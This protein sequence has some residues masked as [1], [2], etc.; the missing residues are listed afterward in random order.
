MALRP[1]N[2]GD[3]PLATAS[4]RRA[5]LDMQAAFLGSL[6][7]LDAGISKALADSVA[8][9]AQ[10]VVDNLDA[11]DERGT[12]LYTSGRNL[13]AL[14]E[15][16]EVVSDLDE[17]T[18]QEAAGVW[19]QSALYLQRAILDAA[20]KMGLSAARDE[21][22]AISTDLVA[23][24]QKNSFSRLSDFGDLQTRTVVDL[25]RGLTDSMARGLARRQVAAQVKESGITALEAIPGKRRAFSLEER[26]SM[27]AR[28]ES[29]RVQTQMTDAFAEAAELEWGRSFLNWNLTSHHDLCLWAESMAWAPVQAF[30][31]GPGLPPRHP[32]CGCMWMRGMKDWID[33]DEGAAAM[34]KD[35]VENL[36]RDGIAL[37][38]QVFAKLPAAVQARLKREAPELAGTRKGKAAIPA[39]PTPVLEAI[40]VAGQGLYGQPDRI[41]ASYEGTDKGYVVWPYGKKPDAQRLSRVLP[42]GSVLRAAEAE[43][44]EPSGELRYDGKMIPE[45]WVGGKREFR[46]T[47][48]HAIENLLTGRE[49]GQLLLVPPMT[50]GS[51]LDL[52]PKEPRPFSVVDKKPPIPESPKAPMTK[53]DRIAYYLLLRQKGMSEPDAARALMR[54]GVSFD[55]AVNTTWDAVG[56]RAP[57][58]DDWRATSEWYRQ[59]EKRDLGWYDDDY[60]RKY[61]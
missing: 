37:K 3:L 48:S 11:F 20:P 39:E 50:R 38:P 53:K 42:H 61:R 9:Q 23:A 25:K 52:K 2:F 34:A 29:V 43:K 18:R 10:V 45:L 27:I 47:S 31:D 60:E 4:L 49:Y 28:T 33:D 17:Q 51:T 26:G 57:S 58:P 54:E 44:D 6:D 30:L 56:K 24:G 13:A 16:V 5:L 19:G 14:Q 40:G 22:S 32:N 41:S 55:D 15:L 36:K 12:Y 59:A 1:N 21:F 46:A 8:R 35:F 7:K